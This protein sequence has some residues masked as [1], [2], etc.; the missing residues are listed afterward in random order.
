MKFS[1]SKCSVKFRKCY[2]ICYILEEENEH[3]DFSSHKIFS[4]SIFC[5]LPLGF[6]HFFTSLLFLSSPDK[7]LTMHGCITKW[8]VCLYTFQAW[9]LSTIWNQHINIIWVG[10]G[11]ETIYSELN[12]H[13]TRYYPKLG[14]VTLRSIPP[15]FGWFNDKKCEKGSGA[16]LIYGGYILC[17]T[18]HI[19]LN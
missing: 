6:L 19:I 10:T 4:W 8:V 18:D 12:Y 9:L 17:C 14:Y 13:T 15:S 2:F 11:L 16:I 5:H 1:F 3:Q 7:L